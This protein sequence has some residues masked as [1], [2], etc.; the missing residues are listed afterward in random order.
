MTG[1]ETGPR[2]EATPWI[3]K[4]GAE[5]AKRRYAGRVDRIVIHR[6]VA[7][8]EVALAVANAVVSFGLIRI[9]IREKRQ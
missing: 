6:C 8:C 7:V 4:S 5:T 9:T 2:R 3:D 1:S